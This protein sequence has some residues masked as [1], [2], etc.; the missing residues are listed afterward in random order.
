MAQEL[1]LFGGPKAVTRT[2]ELGAAGG[3]AF[4]DED[5]AAVL[6]VLDWPNMYASNPQFEEEF[7]EFIGAKFVLGT[8]NGTSAIH[9]AYFAV[10]VQPGDEVIISSHTWHLQVSQILALHGIPVF[11]DVDPRDACIDPE[12]IKRNISDRTRAIAVV[13][14]Y[15]AIAPMDEIMAIAREHDLAVVEDC[16]HAHGATYKGRKVGTI[17]DVG[18]FSLQ[19]S[20]LMIGIEAGVM[21]TDNEEY[22]ERAIVLGHYGRIAQLKS[23]KYLKYNDPDQ[24]EQ[25]PTCFGF[26]Y[27]MNP[28]AAALATAQLRNLPEQNKIR[29]DN[30]LYLTE[31]I[32]E[33]GGDMLRPPYERPD[34]E[35]TWL[36]FICHYFEDATG[37]PRERYIEAVCAEGLHVTGG[38]AGYLPIYWNPLYEERADMWGPGYPFDAPAVTNKVTYER[39]MCPEAERI[40]KR[41]INVPVL[42][43]ECSQELR[44]EIVEA[45]VKPLRNIDALK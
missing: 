34:T 27:R 1:A 26:K 24:A 42:H 17:G 9:S 6:E 14:P 44:D 39:G 35:R 43:N 5:K 38:R 13:H 25:A 7:Q 18:C 37:V 2:D 29:R 19:G 40:W 16:S 11:C 30:A 31:K 12:D 15:G 28:M 22:Y 32:A 20:K 4:T 21:V 23:A 36:N 3:R 10:G 41:G 33:M 8:N 45:L